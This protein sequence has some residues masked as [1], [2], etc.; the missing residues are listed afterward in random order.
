VKKAGRVVQPPPVIPKKITGI[1]KAALN[2]NASDRI[3]NL[4]KP[5]SLPKTETIDKQPR[6]TIK[7]QALAYKPSLRIQQLALPKRRIEAKNPSTLQAN[8]Q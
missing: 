3:K 8:T 2:Y 1:S 6:V 7:P 4:A 5:R